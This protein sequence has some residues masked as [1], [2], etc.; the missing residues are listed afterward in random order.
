MSHYKYLPSKLF[1][2]CISPAVCSLICTLPALYFF[3]KKEKNTDI[4]PAESRD[5]NQ[6]CQL[7]SY[8]DGY[9]H[10]K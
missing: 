7:L 5:L 6:D 10:C 4:S 8:Y 9:G 3:V 2:L 1:D